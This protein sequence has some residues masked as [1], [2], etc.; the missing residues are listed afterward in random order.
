MA[1]WK[2]MGVRHIRR[3]LGTPRISAPTRRKPYCS[4]LLAQNRRRPKNSIYAH[5]MYVEPG[6]RIT[7]SKT[8]ARSQRSPRI[9]R[10]QFLVVSQT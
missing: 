8:E 3:Y 6:T 10:L 9:P 4:L 2:G 7:F 5:D 1:Q